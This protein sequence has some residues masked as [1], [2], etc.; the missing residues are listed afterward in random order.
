MMENDIEKWLKLLNNKYGEPKRYYYN[1][2]GKKY[3]KIIMNSWGQDSVYCFIDKEGNIY[4]AADWRTPAKHIRGN[5]HN[6][7]PLEGCEIYSP[8]YLK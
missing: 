7:D 8:K 5:I 6:P 4:K 1:K 2:A 3:Q